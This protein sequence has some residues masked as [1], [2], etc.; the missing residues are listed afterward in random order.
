[1]PSNYA[2]HRFGQE[3]LK[4][5]PLRQQRAI[6]RMQ[7]LYDAG[8]HG[9]DIFFYSNPF[10]KDDLCALRETCNGLNSREVIA[11]W[12]EV[13]KQHP[14]EGAQAYLYGLLA[15]CCLRSCLMSTLT[16]PVEG[17]DIVD[18]EVEFDRYLLTLDGKTPAQ[19]YDLSRSLK[20][21]RGECLTMAPFFPPAAPGDIHRCMVNFRLATRFLARKRR[22]ALSLW[23]KLTTAQFRRQQ[24]PEHPN[25]RC[26]H[27]DSTLME[28]YRKALMLYPLWAQQLE[29]H[30]NSMDN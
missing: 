12:C 14:S 8:T 25:H 20:V 3:A 1:M 6:G 22:K 10:V 11:R 26:L 2:H 15:Y 7:R 23:L 19:T 27:L 5:L 9:A 30:L 29:A 4:L 28:S 21:T 16:T 17:T 24:M 13:L 18:R